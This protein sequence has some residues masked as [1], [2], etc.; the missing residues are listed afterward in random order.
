MRPPSKNTTSMRPVKATAQPRN[1]IL[2]T[3]LQESTRSASTKMGWK[4]TNRKV[5]VKE[6]MRVANRVD[7]NHSPIAAPEIVCRGSHTILC[8]QG[9][10]HPQSPQPWGIHPYGCVQIGMLIVLA[11]AH[12][13]TRGSLRTVK[14]TVRWIDTHADPCTHAHNPTSP[15]YTPPHS[16]CVFCREQ[17]LSRTRDGV[18]VWSSLTSFMC[19]HKYCRCVCACVCVCVVVPQQHTPVPPGT[20]CAT[21]DS[22]APVACGTA[23]TGPTA[24]A[25]AT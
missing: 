16:H 17:G 3:G 2:W 12:A 13:H 5:C 15:Q 8:Q 10:L 14:L 20:L 24:A 1:C 7:P 19:E 4:F 11:Y 21:A 18:K 25:P 22:C 6:V 23:A 9:H